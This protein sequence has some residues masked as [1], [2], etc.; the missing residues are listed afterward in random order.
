MTKTTRTLLRLCRS[1]ATVS[2]TR[3]CLW[4]RCGVG[5]MSGGASQVGGSLNK[6]NPMQ[7]ASLGRGR[8]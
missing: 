8:P 6:A 3:S 5:G 4:G 1:G 2:G 7:T